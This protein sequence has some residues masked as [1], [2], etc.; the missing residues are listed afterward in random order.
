MIM[1]TRKRHS[2]EQVVRKLMTA[3]RLLAEGK[4]VAR[5]CFPRLTVIRPPSSGDERRSG[6]RCRGLVG[7][8]MARR[9]LGVEQWTDPPF[10]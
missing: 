7:K 10:A 8:Q 6:A 5:T 4:D 9:L 1:A 2:S 3:D